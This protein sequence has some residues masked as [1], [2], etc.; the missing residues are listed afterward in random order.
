MTVLRDFTLSIAAN[1]TVALVGQ[2]GGGKSTVISLLER[3]YD[4]TGGSIS[5]DGKPLKS[6]DPSLTRLNV[7]LVAQE[8]VLFGVSILDNICYGWA[9]K[10]M[11]NPVK[12]P[13]LPPREKVIEVAKM[14]NAHLFIENFTEGYDTLVG[15]RGVKLSGGQKQRIGEGWRGGKERSDEWKIVIYSTS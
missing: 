12:Y 4:V 10:H 15:E 5:I 7:G 13:P 6:L 8:P 14:A 9:A 2:S 1:T 11:S 3:F